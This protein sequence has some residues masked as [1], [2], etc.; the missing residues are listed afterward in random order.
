MG[1]TLQQMVDEVREGLAEKLRMRGRSLDAQIRKA[2]RLLPRGV[3]RDAAYLAQAV[4][5]ADNPKL[6]RMVDLAKAKRAHGRVLS[7]LDTID[8][9]AQRRS[10]ALN[11]VASIGLALLVTAALVLFVLAQRGFL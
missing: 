6:A 4:V 3:K 2:G 7:F 1:M 8:A 9:G 10:A 5:L 11:L